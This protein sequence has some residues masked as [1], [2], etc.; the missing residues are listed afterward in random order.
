MIRPSA[1]ILSIAMAASPAVTAH[2]A[3]SS[4]WTESA[5]S[6]VR[7]IAGSNAGDSPLRAGVEI[8]LREGWHTYWRYPGDS[9]V[10]PQFDFTASDNVKNVEVLWPAPHAVT[11][12]SGT[13]IGYKHNVVFPLRVIPRDPGK[14]VTLRLKLDYAVCEK[15][16]VPEDAKAELAIGRSASALDPE[17]KAAES[18]VPKPASA[19]EAGL[20][21]K[22]VT[23]GNKP[24]VFLDLADTGNGSME[25]FVEGPTPQ[26]SLPI[27]K[28]AQGAP[29]G[30]RHFGFEL[31]GFP[32]GADPKGSYDLTY[33]IV[34]GNRAIEVSAPLD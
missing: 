15:L 2:A 21:A 28:P 26:W 33:T 5:R 14:P 24:L 4:P 9:G 3:D 34:T 8:A 16:C 25:V 19:A 11:D 29:A 13:S 7:L 17:L 23:T 22:R 20:K 12:E 27:P 6:Q 32:P 31:D 30:R 18:Q 10:P 1:F